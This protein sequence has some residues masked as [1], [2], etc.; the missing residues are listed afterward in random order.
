[1]EFKIHDKH[2][3]SIF[4]PNGCVN[5]FDSKWDDLFRLLIN[6]TERCYFAGNRKIYADEN[7][8]STQDALCEELLIN[9]DNSFIVFFR[10]KNAYIEISRK[11]LASFFDYFEF[12]GLFFLNDLKLEKQLIALIEMDT[13]DE[14]IVISLNGLYALSKSFEEGVLWLY[15]S[16]DMEFPDFL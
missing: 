4:D 1:M 3:S 7:F 10:I 6:S 11:V 5:I 15:K 13:S 9:R 8:L 16:K 12:P 2:S 14:E